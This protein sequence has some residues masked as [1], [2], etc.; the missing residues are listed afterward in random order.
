[1]DALLA[2]SSPQEYLNPGC[3]P[4]FP[5]FFLPFLKSFKFQQFRGTGRSALPSTVQRNW[6]FNS[7]EELFKHS[8]TV[9]SS[10]S[11]PMY[12]VG[13]VGLFPSVSL[14]SCNLPLAHHYSDLFAAA[15]ATLRTVDGQV[16]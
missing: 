12:A 7:S 4:S 8:P 15:V 13:H 10:V 16:D 11:L 1:M 14:P 6:S 2:E 3:F 9:L 5:C